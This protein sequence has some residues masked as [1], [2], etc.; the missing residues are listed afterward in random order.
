MSQ[1]ADPAADYDTSV[2]DRRLREADA[3][4]RTWCAVAILVL[5]LPRVSYAADV[6]IEAEQALTPAQ[7]ET[8]KHKYDIQGVKAIP[9][10]GWLRLSLPDPDLNKAKSLAK[11]LRLESWVRR[12]DIAPLNDRDLL[13]PLPSDVELAPDQ[14]TT[15]RR[16]QQYAPRSS[17]VSSIQYGFLRAVL[18]KTI[19]EGPSD[20]NRPLVGFVP[21]MRSVAI[22]TY[23]EES[24]SHLVWS[25]VTLDH[26]EAA[27]GES[28]SV[29]GTAILSIFRDDL[30]DE[31]RIW[32]RIESGEEVV[33]IRPLG[34]GK[35]ILIRV[36][37]DRLRPA[38]E[39]AISVSAEPRFRRAG[40]RKSSTG[41]RANEVSCKN[42]TREC[43]ENPASARRVWPLSAGNVPTIRL[44]VLLNKSTDPNASVLNLRDYANHI[45]DQINVAF[46]ASRVQAKVALSEATEVAITEPETKDAYDNA[47]LQCDRYIAQGTGNCPLQTMYDWR[48]RTK[49]DVVLVLSRSGANVNFAAGFSKN[50]AFAIVVAERQ[51]NSESMATND[52]QLTAL[53]ELGHVFGAA[54]DWKWYRDQTTPPRDAF[55]NV[56]EYGHG[57]FRGIEQ[58]TAAFC[59]I[60]SATVCARHLFWSTPKLNWNELPIGSCDKEDVARLL[61]E[62]AATISRYR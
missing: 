56:C 2:S 39:G 18:Q 45:V 1:T 4:M 44:G 11:R 52:A 25:G 33:L 7:L 46:A 49:S 9:D 35:H 40:K 21:E 3:A 24:D 15:L 30:S 20:A 19:I 5:T 41:T 55:D 60:M 37:R 61:S 6:L 16:V 28:S 51:H 42:A 50:L 36:E 58:S 27:L 32:G 12:S 34:D 10:F 26:D 8:L 31:S 48:N 13:I 38:L 53:H 29:S 54:H 22:G 17:L 62:R 23:F 57:Y 47:F 43:A 59:T 14:L